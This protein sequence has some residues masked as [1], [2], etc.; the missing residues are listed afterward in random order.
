MNK[1]K[2]LRAPFKLEYTYKRSTGPIIGK[3]FDALSKNK[4]LGTK[5]SNGDILVPAAEFDPVTCEELKGFVEVSSTGTIKSFTW[6]NKPRD[7]HL[8]NKPFAFALINLDGT[9]SCM[10]RMVTNCQEEDL[11]M[12]QKVTVVW[13]SK[14]TKTILD[15]KYFELKND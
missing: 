3:F 14:K 4:I 2:M 15:I 7:H 9:S 13:N 12:G 5:N 6:I 8:L 10:L 11:Y 1:D